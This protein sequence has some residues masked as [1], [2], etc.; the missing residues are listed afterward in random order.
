LNGNYGS[1]RDAAMSFVS[2]ADKAQIF[3]KTAATF[4]RVNEM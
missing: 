4:Y 3:G 1:W 2:D